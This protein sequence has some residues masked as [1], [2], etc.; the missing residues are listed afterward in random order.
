MSI[1]DG[2]EKIVAENPATWGE[3]E[4]I[5]DEVLDDYWR[6]RAR[7]DPMIGWSLAKMI[8]EAL[9]NAGLLLDQPPA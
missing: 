8:A 2:R 3:P 1:R 7:P 9:R 5:I 4:K 6:N